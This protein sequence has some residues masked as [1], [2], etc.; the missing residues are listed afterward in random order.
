MTE[1]ATATPLEELS[2]E[3]KKKIQFDFMQQL[4]STAQDQEQAADLAAFM[5]ALSLGLLHSIEGKD[6][7]DG[8]IDSAKASPMEITLVHQPT[9]N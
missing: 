3:V 2:T 6:V 9:L 7:H 1:T 4:I 5:A 8:F